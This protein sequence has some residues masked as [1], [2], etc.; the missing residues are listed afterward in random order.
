MPWRL[1]LGGRSFKRFRYV[2]CSFSVVGDLLYRDT[3]DRT[4]RFTAA[5]ARTFVLIDIQQI[6]V[7]RGLIHRV[8]I[9]RNLPSVAETQIIDAHNTV[10]MGLHFETFFA[11][12]TDIVIDF[13][14]EV[15]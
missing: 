4:Y 9:A 10:F 13:E 5:A 11:I 12:N 14:F 7:V 2:A 6:V 1:A 8:R 3:L 15:T